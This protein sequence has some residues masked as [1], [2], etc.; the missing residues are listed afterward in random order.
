HHVAQ[1]VETVLGAPHTAARWPLP[2]RWTPCYV[3]EVLACV[4]LDC[5]AL[6]A[7]GD[8]VELPGCCDGRPRPPW[9]P[10]PPTATRIVP[11]R[12]FYLVRNTVTLTL[13]DGTE[14]P[15][16]SLRLALEADAWAWSWSARV[17]GAALARLQAEPE[18]PAVE[19]IA[20]VNAHPIRLR[21]DSIARARS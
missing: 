20:T 16:A 6:P 12:R 18:A 9:V 1:P 21:L 13:L 5:R 7:L 4:R 11:I 19:L 14:I 17:P 8:A 10:E 15:A 3:P 2:G